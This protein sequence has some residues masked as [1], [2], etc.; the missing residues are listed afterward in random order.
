MLSEKQ[1][2]FEWPYGY[3]LTPLKNGLKRGL[4][5]LKLIMMGFTSPVFLKDVCLYTFD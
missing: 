4:L 5:L 2:T 3:G 1:T